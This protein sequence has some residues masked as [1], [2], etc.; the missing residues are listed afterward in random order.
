MIADWALLQSSSQ[1]ACGGP[2]AYDEMI[3]SASQYW[4]A[5]YITEQAG[6]S[7]LPLFGRALVNTGNAIQRHLQRL[8]ACGQ[9][10]WV[11]L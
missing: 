2:L 6:S 10:T 8:L 7:K 4:T 11:H 3:L 1:P 9:R 5:L